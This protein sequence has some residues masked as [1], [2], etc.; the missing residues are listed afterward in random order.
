MNEDKA[1]RYNRLKRRA[2]VASLAWGV[3]LLVTLAATGGS[4]VLAAA[5]STVAAGL[6]VLPRAPTTVAVYVM[7][8]ALTNEV[9]ALPLAFYSGFLLEHRYNLSTERA[10]QWLR[11]HVKAGV[12]ALV[13]GASGLTLL[14]VGIA[15]WPERWWIVAGVGFLVV[16]IVLANLGP[17]LLLPLFYRLTPLDRAPLGER[18][19]ALAARARVRA[20]GIFRWT[21]SARTRKA[22]AALTGIGPTRRI[23]LSDTLL[24]DYSDDEIEVIIAHELAHQVHRDIW[25]GI[26]YE[27]GLAFAGFYLAAQSIRE[28][29]AAAGLRSPSD[30]AGLPLLLLSAGA[31]SLLL[32]PLANALS[33]S[34]ER[35]ADRFALDATRNPEAFISAMRRLASQN[36]AE[37]R[38][39][40]IVRVLFHTHPSIEE[41]IAMAEGWRRQ[42][43]GS[44]DGA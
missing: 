22:N 43:G 23:L 28:L 25:R 29:G 7:L 1:T 20:A 5:S 18:L 6:S 3:I 19:L 8:L 30:V 41:R 34:H 42:A 40:R 2:A 36:L 39:T 33:R 32:M 11:E 12:V 38:P 4:R 24:D 27:S 17:V 26:G 9:V 31:V 13:L 14:Y 10:G 15:R 16:T 37:E 35:R 44:R 21:L